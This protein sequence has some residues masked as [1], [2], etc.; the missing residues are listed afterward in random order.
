MDRKR[1]VESGKNVLIVI[2]ATTMLLLSAQLGFISQTFDPAGLDGALGAEPSGW[3]TASYGAAASP[4]CIVVTPETGAH[5]AVMYD[6]EAVDEAYARFSSSLGEALGSA[7][8]P[9]V[10]T[11]GEWEAALSGCGVYFDFLSDQLLSVVA[12]WFGISASGDTARHTARRICLTADSSGVSLYYISAREGIGYRCATMLSYTDLFSKIEEYLPD[13]TAFNFELETPFGLVDSCAVIRSG[14]LSISS[15][16]VKNPLAG[17]AGA[18]ELMSAFGMNSILAEPYSEANGAHGY[19]E[20]DAVL[21]VAAD[22]T[23]TYWGKDRSEAKVSLSPAEAVEAARVLCK[24]TLGA[25]CGEA[26]LYMSYI[27]YVSV[28]DTY[29]MRFDYVLNG[30]P[31]V[32]SNG[33]SAAELTL[34]GTGITSAKMQFRE[35]SS[36]QTAEEPLPALQAAAAVEALGGGE[37][38]LSYIDNLSSVSVGWVIR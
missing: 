6:G 2:L 12:G 7:G 34:T 15:V 18:D 10:V 5:C 27:S 33:E 1:L 29:S 13:G 30:L 26:S 37:P 3:E 22:G 16:S 24:K 17:A 32:F 23:L 8:E 4:F 11:T 20:G 38:M 31:V 36:L 9:E 28:S 25:N 14:P 35:Y 19:V 21:R